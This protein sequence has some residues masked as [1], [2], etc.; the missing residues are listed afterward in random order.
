MRTDSPKP[1]RMQTNCAFSPRRRFS[2]RLASPT[3]RPM[4]LA[5]CLWG[6][7]AGAGMAQ[8]IFIAYAI[9]TNTPGNQ[10][11][12]NAEPIGTDFD[13]A[14]EI[15]VTRLG[16]FDA[17]SDGFATGTILTTRLWDRSLDPPVQLAAIDFTLDSPGEL[18]GGSR[19][20]P[21]G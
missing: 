4:M 20:K 1:V 19:F 13:V 14:N 15:I 8:D 7:S 12:L 21:L 2:Q 6:A 16:V 17:S 10:N 5:V 18:V 11:G 3:F 9:P